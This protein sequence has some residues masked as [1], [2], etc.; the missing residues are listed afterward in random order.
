MRI[1]T[2]NIADK[3]ILKFKRLLYVLGP[4]V[5]EA[6][7]QC[8]S[9]HITARLNAREILTTKLG[10]ESTG[11]SDG[12]PLL[13]PPVSLVL[14]QQW[15]NGTWICHLELDVDPSRSRIDIQYFSLEKDC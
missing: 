13:S 1:A 15:I 9:D 10:V 2:S 7:P 12:G 4:E 8:F 5:S 6:W 3:F 14:R 11:F